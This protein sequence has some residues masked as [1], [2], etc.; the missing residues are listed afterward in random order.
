MKNSLLL[1]LTLALCACNGTVLIG[2]PIDE[3]LLP[4]EVTRSFDF[5]QGAQGWLAGFSDYPVDNADIF[6]LEADIA[7]LPTDSSRSGFLLTGHNRSDDLFMYL[8]Y[9]VTGLAANTRYQLSGSVDFLSNG[10]AGCF[11]IGGAPGE[12]VYIKMGATELEPEQADYYMNIDIGAQSN[13]GNDSKVLGHIGV[14]GISCDGNSYGAKTLSLEATDG[15]EIITSAQ[16]TAW[17]YVGS[18]SGFEG[19]T[20]LYYTNISFTLKP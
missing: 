20:D 9:E 6:E 16:G 14:D 8:K 13:E 18:D 4:S 1:L 17:I 19:R 2:D 12:S 5:N 7:E 10:A 15:F 3:P 11:G